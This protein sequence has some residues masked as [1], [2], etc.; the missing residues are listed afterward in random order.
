MDFWELTKLIFRRWM[1]AVP[2]LFLIGAALTWMYVTVS[3]DYRAVAHVQLIP[4]QVQPDF[5][6]N[7]E[8][9]N[10]P[11]AQL[12]AEALG[13]AV[14]LGMQRPSFADSL[15]AEGLTGN[16]SVSLDPEFP[17]VVVEAVGA[18]PQQATATAQR[19]SDLVMVEV[20][21]QQ[22][23][24]DVPP[25]KA[26]STL[27]L[28]DGSELSPDSSSKRRA[29]VAVAGLGLLLT[30][31]TCIAVDALRYRHARRLHR[32]PGLAPWPARYVPAPA[33]PAGSRAAV[34]LSR[35]FPLGQPATVPVAGRFPPFAATGHPG[36]HN[37]HPGGHHS[38]PA[39]VAHPPPNGS[40]ALAPA[41]GEA[42]AP[43]RSRVAEDATGP[44]T[45]ADGPA[46]G[47]GSAQASAEPVAGARPREVSDDT[48]VLP[49]AGAARE[50]A[51][52]D[53]E[54]R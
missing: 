39:P 33:L 31:G 45:G 28:D 17:I 21:A 22:A 4:P 18:T 37:P 25:E 42:S 50:L 11:W 49:L 6:P 46:G 8:S 44:A 27:A 54:V 9:G 35:P 20:D 52:P 47:T 30:A 3:P 40:D 38:Q 15:Q 51:D 34:G 24:Y 29:L 12:G 2:L 26:I 10:N 32:R 16:F 43:E 36:A 13:Q 14:V 23:Q 5:S 1:V 19:L 48:V 53:G 41:R 7:A